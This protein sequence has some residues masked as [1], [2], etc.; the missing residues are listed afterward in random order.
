VLREQLERR[1]LPV[2]AAAFGAGYVLG[3]GLTLRVT[4][5]LLANA[6]RLTAGDLVGTMAT[7]VRRVEEEAHG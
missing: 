2:L 6:L 3:G 4:S 1:P 5:I 7:R